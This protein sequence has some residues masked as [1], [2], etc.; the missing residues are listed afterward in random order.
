MVYKVPGFTGCLFL[1]CTSGRRRAVLMKPPKAVARGGH[2]HYLERC[3]KHA[4][5]DIQ[6]IH[7]KE[8]GKEW[9][10]CR[11]K[12][13][14]EIKCRAS[15]DQCYHSK[16]GHKRKNVCGGLCL[17][18]GTGHTQGKEKRERKKWNS[19]QNRKLVT[20]KGIE[21]YREVSFPDM[22]VNWCVTLGKAI[23]PPLLHFHHT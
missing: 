22:L 21:P 5:E 17:G 12:G 4:S 20:Q 8:T 14:L 13:D 3:C 10:G 9:R 11:K 6:Q 15:G 7:T 18:G 16:R 23:H 2:K 19:V 1:G